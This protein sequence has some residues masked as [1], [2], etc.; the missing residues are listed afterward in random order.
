MQSQDPILIALLPQPI[1]LE[2]ARDG[3]YRVPL[4]HAPAA[5]MRAKALAFY[6]P[7]SFGDERWQVAWYARV[8]SVERARRRDLIPEEPTHRR[9]N[10]LYV[11]V[12]LAA[13]VPVEPPK[14]AQKGRRLLFVT[15][16]WG[17]FQTA[18]S[19]DE[20]LARP[21]RPIA[22][23]PLYGIIRQQL[24]DQEGIADPDSTHQKRLFEL[25]NA[26]FAKLDW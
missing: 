23:D 26:A 3:W 15:T 19:L 7:A 18:K 20:L 11:C 22:D 12:R 25:G 17:A 1:D 14:Q 21:P 16:T 2:R 6:Q 13:L 9:A 10:E 24:A 8:R 4:A 5:L